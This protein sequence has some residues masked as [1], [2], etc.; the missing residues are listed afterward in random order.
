VPALIDEETFRRVGAQLIRNRKLSKKNAKRFYLLRGLVVCDREHGG[1]GSAYGGQARGRGRKGRLGEQ[2]FYRC[3]DHVHH[4]HPD[5][6]RGEHCRAAS[7]DADKLE[8]L[9]WAD[10]AYW[11]RHPDE[12]LAEAQEQLRRRLGQ[13]ASSEQERRR[14]REAL[15][16]KDEERERVM[17]L[18]RRKRSTLEEAERDLD[19]V[20]QEAARI[21]TLLDAMQA[22][23]D[24]ARAYEAQYAEDRAA[25]LELARELDEIERTNNLA[26]KRQI[27]ER[28]VAGVR[29]KPQGHGIDGRVSVTYRFS[30][31]RAHAYEP[32][33]SR[34]SPKNA[35]LR[36]VDSPQFTG[37][38]W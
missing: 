21:R 10:C 38:F 17:T 4:Y 29:V 31:P 36:S 24:L 14:L 13:V 16:E 12:G 33:I 22:Q 35:R 15:A 1:C 25:L 37:T 6:P 34:T 2:R 18:Y 19:K 23:E 27:V 7:V 9:I 3:N 28:L 8:A 32:V 30:A 5:R 26:K 20:A 11:L